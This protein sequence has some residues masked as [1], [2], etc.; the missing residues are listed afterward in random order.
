MLLFSTFIVNH[1][2]IEVKVKVK[3]ANCTKCL[4]LAGNLDKNVRVSV[5]L[6]CGA[7]SFMVE[8]YSVYQRVNLLVHCVLLLHECAFI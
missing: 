8:L 4:S 3:V 1:S 7:W 5:I 2:W 6:K